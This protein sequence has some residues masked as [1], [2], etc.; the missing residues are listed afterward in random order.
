LPAQIEE[1]PEYPAQV[2]AYLKKH[3]SRTLPWGA[4]VAGGQLTQ[5]RSYRESAARHEVG[6]TAIALLVALGVTEETIDALVGT[7]AGQLVTR[8]EELRNATPETAS[9]EIPTT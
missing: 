2:A 7:P 1:S 9:Q 6:E 8:L 5:T 3:G 4:I